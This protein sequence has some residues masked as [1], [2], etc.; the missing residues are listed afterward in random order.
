MVVD[1]RVTSKPIKTLNTLVPERLKI[2]LNAVV[3]CLKK[4]ACVCVCVVF[5]VCVV[6]VCLCVWCVCVVC[7]CVCDVCVMC[8]WC[9][10][11]VCVC[12]CVNGRQTEFYCW[13]TLL[14]LLSTSENKTKCLRK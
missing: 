1:F 3:T 12:V 14:V 7:V 11:G 5:C 10:C 6:C 9:V 4:T 2:V 13:S 8:V